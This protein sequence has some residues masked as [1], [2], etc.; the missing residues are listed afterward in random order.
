MDFVTFF[1][2][3]VVLWMGSRQEAEGAGLPMIVG[4][5]CLT[6]FGIVWVLA[7]RFNVF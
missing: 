4:G 7:K 6:V 1:I 5:A 3:V 2:G